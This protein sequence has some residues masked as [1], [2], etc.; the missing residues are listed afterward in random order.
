MTLAEAKRAYAN[1]EVINK[2]LFGE[3]SKIEK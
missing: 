3:N 1:S 2:H